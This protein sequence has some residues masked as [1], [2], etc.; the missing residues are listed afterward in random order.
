MKTA[1]RGATSVHQER[2]EAEGTID[3]IASG[4]GYV[5][6]G[7]ATGKSTE[8]VF[9]HGSDVGM[10][11]HGDRVKV[12]IG[13]GRGNRPEGKVLRVLS[14]RRTEFV[15]TIHKHQGRLILVSGRPE[16]ATPFLI[17]AADA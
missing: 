12:R 5:R 3:I 9:V 13:G 7:S 1:R 17:P 2:D 15:G 14:R 8:D 16:G 10:A 11:L 4:A 6:L